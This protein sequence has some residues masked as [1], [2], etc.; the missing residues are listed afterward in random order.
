MTTNGS[1]PD[2][3][4][5]EAAGMAEGFITSDFISMSY[6]NTLSSYCVNEKEYCDKL[7]KFLTDNM[8][9]INTQIKKFPKSNYW[10][11]VSYYNPS[12]YLSAFFLFL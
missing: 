3:L 4:Q 6:Q 8:N 7:N 11:Q 10:H 2:M 5:A 12:I 1:Y 9:W